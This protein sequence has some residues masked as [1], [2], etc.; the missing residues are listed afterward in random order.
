M[1][2]K[3]LHHPCRLE[4]LQ[5]STRG[6]N[7]KWPFYPSLLGGPHVDKVATSPLLSQGDHRDDRG[8][9]ATLPTCGPP[10]RVG[11]K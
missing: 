7:Q 5:H 8:D 1:W 11:V 4:G 10:N 2:A 9:I 3:W 6:Q